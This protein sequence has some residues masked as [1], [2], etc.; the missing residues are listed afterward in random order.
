[1]DVLHELV[2]VTENYYQKYLGGYLKEGSKLL[3]LYNLVKENEFINDEQ[4]ALLL[5]EALPSDKKYL[6]LKHNL[7][8]KL[9]E[10]MLESED[11]AVGYAELRFQVEKQII[12]AEK[13]LSINV[14]HTSEKIAR[15]SLVELNG[16]WFVDLQLRVYRLLRKIYSLKGDKRKL[17]QVIE[18]IANVSELYAKEDELLT[19]VQVHESSFKYTCSLKGSQYDLLKQMVRYVDE[20]HKPE[21]QSL[22]FYLNSKRLKVYMSYAENNPDLL[23]KS[24]ADFNSFLTHE[25]AFFEQ[26]E[27]LFLTVFEIR[28]ALMLDGSNVE[29]L[30][31][32]A[33][34]ISSYQSFDRFEVDAL[35]FQYLTYQSRFEH[36]RQVVESVLNTSQFDRLDPVDKG[37]WLL[38]RSIAEVLMFFV[39]DE[40]EASFRVSDAYELVDA[41]QS[42]SK[43]KAG[44]NM[45]LLIVHTLILLLSEKSEALI[46]KGNSLKVYF[47]RYL[48]DI[49]E[50]RV[51]VF[52]QFLIKLCMNKNNQVKTSELHVMF[53]NKFNK[54]N[55]RDPNEFFPY[56][57]FV[58]SIAAKFTI[59]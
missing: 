15:R 44:Y 19:H 23:K 6:M 41:C 42:L 57:V 5:Y 17:I 14:F 51:K 12:V 1:M 20:K 32:K 11:D 30:F 47:Y 39:S 58:K 10:V 22:E 7:T 36:A 43:D 35:Y 16:E 37:A 18:S 53:L 56:E 26:G 27:A 50:Q 29:N 3:A 34:E 59:Q 46:D 40:L 2:F 9:N 21:H 45:H 48:K 31:S 33:F 4:A 8:K 24:L 52:F 49:S 13:L 54:M 25:G 28:A 38:R 55:W